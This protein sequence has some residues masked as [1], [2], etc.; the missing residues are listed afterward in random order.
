VLLEKGLSYHVCSW[1][2]RRSRTVEKGMVVLHI[3]QGHKGGSLR[4]LFQ[5]VR[6]GRRSESGRA[7]AVTCFGAFSTCQLWGWGGPGGSDPLPLEK[8]WEGVASSRRQI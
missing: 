7:T 2:T 1:G 6:E 4:F 3:P 5:G 8:P